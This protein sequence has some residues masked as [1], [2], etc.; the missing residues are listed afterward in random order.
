M[1]LGQI[2]DVVKLFFVTASKRDIAE[3]T[4]ESIFLIPWNFRIRYYRSVNYM[5]IV[6]FFCYMFIFNLSLNFNKLVKCA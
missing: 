2:Y 6:V 4:K 5:D 3:L 1:E